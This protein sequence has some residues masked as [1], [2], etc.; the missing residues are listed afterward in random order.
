MREGN[1]DRHLWVL[2]AGYVIASLTYAIFIPWGGNPDEKAHYEYIQYLA[3]EHR[4]P[5]FR[6][7]EVLYEAH[8]PPL[9]Y[10][11][12]LPFYW[13]GG[14]LGTPKVIR[15]LAVLTGAGVLACTYW[16]TRRLYPK[17]EGAP[18]LAGAVAGFLPSMLTMNASVGND[19]LATLVFSVFALWCAGQ[20]R[21]RIG[22]KTGL[23][24]GALV[25]LGTLTKVPCAVLALLAAAAFL[26]FSQ[27]GNG[28]RTFP[29]A[30]K[31]KPGRPSGARTLRDNPGSTGKQV[32]GHLPWLALAS[33]AGTALVICGWWL[34]RNQVLYGDPFALSRF[35]EIFSRGRPA[36]AYFFSRGFSFLVY[37]GVVATF[38]FKTFWGAFG[39][40]NIFLPHPVYLF[41]LG[42][43]GVILIGWTLRILTGRIGTRRNRAQEEA[44][45]LGIKFA[46]LILVLEFAFLFA[47]FLRFN[48]VFFQGQARYVLLAATPI[49]IFMAVGTLAVFPRRWRKIA[50]LLLS[51]TFF[52]Y[53]MLALLAWGLPA[54]SRLP[55][56]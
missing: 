4:L 55:Y 9:Y 54:F 21:G 23:G 56:R 51:G 5:V 7:S 13:L 3:E 1:W 35:V 40:A 28:G 6:S 46:R 26:V 48:M 24:M 14:L 2:L 16:T 32:K 29:P 10:L 44:E 49:A 27:G 47:F 39:R 37:L 22:T 8:Q 19:S 12:A 20:G 17:E 25:G 36:P 18:L 38:T 41:W 30:R 50:A 11:L 31:S 42:V 52:A 34:V 43:S 45:G 53:G 33:A 15:L